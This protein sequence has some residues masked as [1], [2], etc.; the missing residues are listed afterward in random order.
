LYSINSLWSFVLLLFLI[1]KMM[2][3]FIFHYPGY[4]RERA[5]E[6]FWIDIWLKCFSIFFTQSHLHFCVGSRPSGW[7]FKNYRVE[8]I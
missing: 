6:L 5:K 1:N 2:P 3:L 4:M 8:I 7:I